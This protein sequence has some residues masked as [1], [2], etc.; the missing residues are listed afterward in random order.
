MNIEKTCADAIEVVERYLTGVDV[1]YA[2]IFDELSEAMEAADCAWDESISRMKNGTC[3][4]ACMLM[5]IRSW[6]ACIAAKS[7][8][9]DLAKMYVDEY[10]ELVK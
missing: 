8:E 5:S 2:D 10:K 6:G 3:S 1:H 4:T 7:D 9:R